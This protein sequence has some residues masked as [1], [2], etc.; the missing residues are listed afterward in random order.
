MDAN[1]RVMLLILLSK[2]IHFYGCARS[3]TNAFVINNGFS[4]S[5]CI[6]V[7]SGCVSECVWPL[8]VPV[9]LCII[10]S[11]VTPL[12]FAEAISGAH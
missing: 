5:E 9:C 1:K 10:A 4:R 2:A 12:G 11:A 7:A 6:K 3:I 8:F